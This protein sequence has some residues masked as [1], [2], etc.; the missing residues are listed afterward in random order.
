MNRKFSSM[1][2]IA[3]LTLTSARFLGANPTIASLSLGSPRDFQMKHK[4]DTSAKVE[5]WTLQTGTFVLILVISLP[6][7]I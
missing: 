2:H 4:K 7:V 5:R 6:S 3:L 1:V